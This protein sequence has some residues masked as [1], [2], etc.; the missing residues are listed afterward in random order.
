MYFKHVMALRGSLIINLS[1]RYPLPYNLPPAAAPQSATMLTKCSAIEF[2][3]HPLKVCGRCDFYRRRNSSIFFPSFQLR[4][5]FI[6][7]FSKNFHFVLLMGN[8]INFGKNSQFQY[9]RNGCTTPPM[10]LEIDRW[11]GRL[12]KTSTAI[13]ITQILFR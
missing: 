11:Q 3:F 8:A 10:E 9:F 1:N 4:T 6:G 13:E 12:L 5:C 2:S 7:I